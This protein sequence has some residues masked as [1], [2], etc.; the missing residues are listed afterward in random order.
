ML[1]GGKG[2]QL[3]WPQQALAAVLLRASSS[4]TSAVRQ[5]VGATEAWSGEGHGTSLR[6]VVASA[7][8]VLVVDNELIVGQ[9]FCSFMRSHAP[10]HIVMY[11]Q[12]LALAGEG[13]QRW[14]G[15]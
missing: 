5:A 1:S 7:L 6:R 14:G 9:R 2:R 12:P 10:Q 8:V 11:Q 13:H 4:A 3:L 15:E